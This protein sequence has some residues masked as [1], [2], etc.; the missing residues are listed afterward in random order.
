[1][2]ERGE[3]RLP[4]QLP[5][6]QRRNHPVHLGLGHRE[7]LGVD[8]GREGLPGRRH[9]RVPLARMPRHARAH[10]HDL[11]A[12][13][14]RNGLSPALVGRSLEHLERRHHHHLAGR[15]LLLHSGQG[16]EREFHH[17]HR[18]DQEQSRL[19]LYPRATDADLALRSELQQQHDRRGAEHGA[20]V[21]QRDRRDAGADLRRVREVLA[22]GAG[23]HAH[24]PVGRVLLQLHHGGR[25][26]DRRC[27]PRRPRGRH[28]PG[29]RLRSRR[30][31]RHGH[32]V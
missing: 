16:A 9:R 32:R 11:P 5:V 25:R 2:R 27:R 26:P 21:D 7:L 29:V 12:V 22:Q 19:P 1:M 23:R 3:R 18:P 17:Q 30:H 28:R 8:H 20:G 31:R 14:R 24:G 4:L 13:H 6:E 15:L 10:E